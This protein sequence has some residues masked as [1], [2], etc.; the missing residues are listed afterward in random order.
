MRSARSVSGLPN[1]VWRHPAFWRLTGAANRLLVERLGI[2]ITSASSGELHARWFERLLYFERLLERVDG[3][4]GDVVECGVANGGGLAALA[5]LVRSSGRRRRLVGFDSWEGLPE[6]TAQ[7]FAGGAGI[8]RRGLFSTVRVEDVEFTLRRFGFSTNEIAENV[9]LVPGWLAETLPRYDG[10]IALLH[11]DVDLYTSYLECLEQ[12]WP[13]LSAGGIVAF[14][15]YRDDRT[16]WPGAE[17]AIDEF[18]GRLDASS[19]SI[20]QDAR[21]GKYFA[22]KTR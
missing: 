19:Y 9:L 18:F 3:V 20:E 14:D 12:L 21:S 22:V 4:E 16:D 8:A 6:P 1:V 10:A 2:R 7:D 13:R 17:R 11:A 15:E 5:A